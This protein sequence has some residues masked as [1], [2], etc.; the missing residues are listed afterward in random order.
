MQALSSAVS[1]LTRLAESS[2]GVV[3]TYIV[4]PDPREFNP[5]TRRCSWVLAWVG[6]WVRNDLP[7]PYEKTHR[8]K[9]RPGLGRPSK[10]MRAF[11]GAR[12]DLLAHREW[13]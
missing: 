5:G 6:G 7:T 13:V 4:D 9:R 1:G 8:T 12:G 11:R 2:G 3:P 10:K